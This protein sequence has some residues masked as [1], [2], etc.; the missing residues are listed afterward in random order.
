MFFEVYDR[1]ISDRF[2]KVYIEG[3]FIDTPNNKP[4]I[5]I[6]EDLAGDDK[7]FH[8][9][10]YRVITKRTYRKLMISLIQ[11]NLTITTTWNLHWI[12]TTMDLNLQ[13]S[14]SD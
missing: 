10:L 13:E 1:D 3:N 9:E 5:E 11:K 2:N 4:N 7:I 6:L 12:G 8:E 14:T